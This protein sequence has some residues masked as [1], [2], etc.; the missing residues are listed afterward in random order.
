VILGGLRATPTNIMQSGNA[1]VLWRCT[2]IV[3]LPHDGLGPE[4]L[5]NPP[6]C[7]EWLDLDWS[8]VD[9]KAVGSTPGGR[10]LPSGTVGCNFRMAKHL[11]V[12]SLLVPSRFNAV[13]P[14]FKGVLACAR[15]SQH[16]HFWGCVRADFL[17]KA[18]LRPTRGDLWVMSF[19]RFFHSEANAP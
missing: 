11:A 12:S 6:R 13:T 18:R 4:G 14:R 3:C 5:Q 16:P 9:T 19:P 8:E 7:A 17:R 15:G 10:L 1:S 2:G